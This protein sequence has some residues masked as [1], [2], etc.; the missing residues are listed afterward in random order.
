MNV[1]FT[2]YYE[3]NPYQKQLAENL[4]SLGVEVKGVD[5]SDSFVFSTLFDRKIDVLHVHWLSIFY[6]RKNR[7]ISLLALFKLFSKLLLIKVQRK[8][9][10]WTVH[11]LVDHENPYPLLDKI[12]NRFMSRIADAVIV[13]CYLAKAEVIKAFHLP[14]STQKFFVIPHGNYINSYTNEKSKF[15]ARRI[16]GISEGYLVILFFGKIRAYKGVQELIEA[17]NLI[18]SKKVILLIAGKPES[19]EL[20]EYIA[21]RA[22]ESENIIFVPSFIPDDEVE[23]YMNACDVVAFPYR[24]ILTSGAVILAMSFGKPCIAPRRGCI[25]EVL[26][27]QGSFIYDLDS[28]R[29]N[30]VNAIKNA[31]DQENM[32]F[33]MGKH[34][35]QLAQ[36]MQW[37]GIAKKTLEVYQRPLNS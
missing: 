30:L 5:F 13:H 24:E 31:I 26:D 6:I 15:D 33:E 4:T 17:F 21:R 29:N 7:L 36:Q 12:C 9:I 28:K 22:T 10:V 2:P 19:E 3:R 25:G 8:R 11:N 35:F 23:I 27:D 16:L 37:L 34:N 32:L 1:F 14:E 18:D 20:R